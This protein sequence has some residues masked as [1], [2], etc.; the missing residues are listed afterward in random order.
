MF[1]ILSLRMQ[2]VSD[3]FSNTPKVTDLR[4]LLFCQS[5]EVDGHGYVLFPDATREPLVQSPLLLLDADAWINR[6]R[7]KRLCS[8]GLFD[9]ERRENCGTPRAVFVSLE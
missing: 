9:R 8:A 2:G 7:L 3:Q 6:Y 4:V 1:R 5:S